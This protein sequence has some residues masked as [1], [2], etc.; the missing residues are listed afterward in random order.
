MVITDVRSENLSIL[1]DRFPE[2]RVEALD[3][4]HPIPL[5]DSPFDVVH[6]YGLLYHLSNPAQALAYLSAS[7]RHLLLLE[8]CVSVAGDSGFNTVTEIRRSPSQ[9]FSGKGCRPARQWVF[10]TLKTHF[11]HVYVPL[12]QPNHEQFPV[13]WNSP[14]TGSLTRAIFVASREPLENDSLSSHLLERQTRHE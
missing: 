13:D 6:C 12:T 2:E 10:D 14:P 11:R 4:E 3:M 9:A 1:R 7:T 8:T 5:T